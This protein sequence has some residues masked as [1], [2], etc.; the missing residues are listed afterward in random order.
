MPV[1]LS[2]PGLGE[3]DRI[4]VGNVP[5][6]LRT[7][8]AGGGLLLDRERLKKLERKKMDVRV[9]DRELAPG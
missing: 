6:K 1:E 3:L 8:R 5:A 9:G 7:E 2:R 4:F